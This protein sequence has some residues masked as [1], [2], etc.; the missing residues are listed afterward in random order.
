M[1]LRPHHLMCTQGYSGKGY[2]EEFVKNMN[3]VTNELRYNEDCVIE[4]VFSTDDI[5]KCCPNMVDINLC[6]TNNKVNSIDR[7]V[8]EYFNLEDKKYIYKDIVS[9]IKNN[10]TLDIMDDI[11]KSCEWYSMSQCREKICENIV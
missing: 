1:K 10:I 6:K 5:C 3:I 4:I 11:C 7:K 2:D 9:C 8:I